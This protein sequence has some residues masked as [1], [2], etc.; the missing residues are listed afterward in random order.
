M[1]EERKF[2]SRWS[3]R[4]LEAAKPVEKPA[5]KTAVTP[6]LPSPDSLSF[7]SDFTAYLAANVEERVKR[8]ALKKLLHDPRFNVMDGLD[9][10]IDDYTKNEPISEAM[11]KTLEHARSTFL[12]LET[13]KDETPAEPAQAKKD[14]SEPGGDPRQDA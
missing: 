5:E 13:P 14:D 7:D 6:E 2:L 4:K 3:R 10:Y 9:T 11:L 1:S 8:A 12:G